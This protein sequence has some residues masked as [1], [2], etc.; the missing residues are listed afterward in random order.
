MMPLR[1][2]LPPSASAQRHYYFDFIS[3]ISFTLMFA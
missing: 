2:L 3:M 1:C